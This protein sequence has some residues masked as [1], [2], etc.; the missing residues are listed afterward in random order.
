[1]YS[2]YALDGDDEPNDNTPPLLNEFDVD[3][4]KNA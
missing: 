3:V 2:Y 4:M 1:M